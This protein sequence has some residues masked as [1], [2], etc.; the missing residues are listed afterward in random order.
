MS[1]LD[2]DRQGVRHPRH[3][4]RSAQRRGRPRARGRLRPLRRRRRD[5]SSAAT[6]GRPAPSSS[7][8]SPTAC[9]SQGVDVVDLGLASSD[10]LYFA[11]GAPRPPGRDV[12]RVAQPGRVQRDQALPRRAPGRSAPT[13][14]GEIKAVASRRARRPRPGAGGRAPGTRRERD[15]LAGVRRPRRCR[16]STRRRC[17]RC[18]SSPTP[19]TGWAGSS[20]RR[21]SSGCRTIELEVMY[22]ELDGT[23]PN[24]PADPLQPANQRDLRARVRRR[25]VRPRAR[26]RRRRRPGVRRRRDRRRAVRLDDDGDARRGDAAHATRARRSCTT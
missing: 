19:P 8:R 18:G 3:G 9:C 16:S 22:G 14:L 20:C 10:L 12:H 25:R 4:A 24:H 13:G 23:F 1:V 6:C 15:L 5:R 11:A 7:T 17:A 2:R 21:C 26:L